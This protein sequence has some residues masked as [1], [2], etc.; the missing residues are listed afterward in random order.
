M[1]DTLRLTT[2]AHFEAFSNNPN[3]VLHRHRALFT[4]RSLDDRLNSSYDNLAT[5]NR[6]VIEALRVVSHHDATLREASRVLFPDHH[7]HSSDDDSTY[8]PTTTSTLDTLSLASTTTTD[9]TTVT[10]SSSSATVTYCRPLH[11]SSSSDTFFNS[12][13]SYNIHP[14]SS[15]ADSLSTATSTTSDSHDHSSSTTTLDTQHS[16]IPSSISWHTH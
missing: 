2:V 5:W 4:S 10:Q 6:S 3:I 11:E 9:A 7:Q 12:A 1:I 15:N 8:A 16:S 13:T 14:S